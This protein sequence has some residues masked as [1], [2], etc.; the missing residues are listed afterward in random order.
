[1]PATNEVALSQSARYV[2]PHRNGTAS[3]T[4]YTKEQLFDLYRSHHPSLKE[5]LPNLYIGGWQPD[6]NNSTSVTWGKSDSARDSQPSADVCWDSDAGTEPLGLLEM[7]DEEKE[8]CS[9][10]DIMERY[11]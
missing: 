8:V 2:P 1:M 6:S 9:D 5:G 10:E 3:D 7:D 11:M 4:R